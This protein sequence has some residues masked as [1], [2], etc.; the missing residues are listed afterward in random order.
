MTC[1]ICDKPASRQH[2]PFCSQGCR[3]RDLL[4][5]LNEGYRVPTRPGDEDEDGLD[6]PDTS[7]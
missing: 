6:S 4:Q 3:D 2:T 5:W 7:H 1:P